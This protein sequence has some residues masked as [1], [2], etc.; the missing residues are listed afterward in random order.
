MTH[1]YVTDTVLYQ[2]NI[3][4]YI[5]EMLKSLMMM[6][7]MM[8]MQTRMLIPMSLPPKPEQCTQRHHGSLIRPV[9]SMWI[10]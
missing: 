5:G 6:M 10:I 4:L 8:K 2:Y 9:L 7:T 3:L 1:N